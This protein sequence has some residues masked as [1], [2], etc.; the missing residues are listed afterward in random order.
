[1]IK[2]GVFGIADETLPLLELLRRGRG[3]T[4]TG[5]HFPDG[6]VPSGEGHPYPPT[7]DPEMLI[8]RSDVLVFAA[9]APADLPFMGEAL[10]RS[11]PL[12]LADTSRLDPP[13]LEQVALLAAE[14]E[15]RVHCYDPLRDHPR[16]MQAAQT[17]GRILFAEVERTFREGEGLRQQLTATLLYSLEAMLS[18]NP[19][20]PRR[21]AVGA[22][23]MPGREAIIHIQL[24]FDD[25][26][27][28]VIRHES[29]PRARQRCRLAG[30]RQT[31]QFDPS[32][33]GPHNLAAPLRHAALWHAWQ[34]LLSP[35]PDHP[36][37]LEQ[38]IEALRLHRETLDQLRIR[39][40]AH[41]TGK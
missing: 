24:L 25:G 3:Y 4:I 8:L 35:H 6:P 30:S 34:Q 33:A 12:F 22:C 11:R 39:T 32:T 38:R 17:A 18:L 28:A 23:L 7:D 2:I 9:P 1:M 20:R 21:P 19:T 5:L 41:L 27:T 14:A 37:T 31:V 29:G 36:E 10:R 15:V 26:M 40:P 13:H 16:F